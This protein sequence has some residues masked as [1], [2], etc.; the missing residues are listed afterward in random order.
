MAKQ[1]TPEAEEPQASARTRGT[2]RAGLNGDS[3]AGAKPRD[4][5]GRCREKNGNRVATGGAGILDRDEISR[6]RLA[7]GLTH[8][9]AARAAGWSYNRRALWCAIESGTY[10]PENGIPL[11]MLAGIAAA[12]H[13]HPGELL[14]AP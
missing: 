9:D 1:H 5:D 12:L 14:R 4:Q 11:G 2:R 8:T 10:D 13:C 6:R 3:H 7:L